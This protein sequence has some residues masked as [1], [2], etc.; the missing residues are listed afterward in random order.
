MKI[1]FKTWCL[2]AVGIIVILLGTVWIGI[3]VE[4]PIDRKVVDE[5]AAAIET[6]AITGLAEDKEI[7]LVEL[8]GLESVDREASWI[9]RDGNKQM[10]QVRGILFDDLSRAFLGKYQQDFHAIRLSAG[11]GYSIEVP[12]AILRN[13]EI[14]LAY[15]INGQPLA[16]KHQP[17]RVIIPN[18]RRMFWVF[19]LIEI[20]LIQEV[21]RYE[22]TQIVILETA[23][24]TVD[25]HD[26]LFDGE[27]HK[28]IRIEAIMSY[29]AAESTAVDVFIRAAD[30]LERNERED[31][32][33][34]EG[35]LKITGDCAPRFFAPELPRGMHVRGVLWFSYGE[36]VF[37]SIA[38]GLD[39]FGPTGERGGLALKE[40]VG[41]TGLRRGESYMFTAID[42]SRVEIAAADI[43]RG[44]I[45]V[46]DE[47]EH[48]AYFAGME[49]AIKGVVVY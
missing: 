15:E 33:I 4:E 11:D 26:H 41:E 30:G 14:I 12:C 28:T 36:T 44:V 49:K 29:F 27:A 3:A 17:L 34:G 40:V 2:I 22:T 16:P 23:M 5:E 37:F 35:Y 18:E 47:G 24:G 48:V 25:Q 9:D 46:T 32:F 43:D 39:L 10:W 7:C 19:Y 45:Y 42:G 1:N 8:K 13:R 20:E 21:V 38:R 6:L 31:I